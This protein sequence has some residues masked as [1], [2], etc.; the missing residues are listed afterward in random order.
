LGLEVGA[1]VAD[2]STLVTGR[3][4]PKR[5]ALLALLVGLPKRDKL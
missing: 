1:P 2:R 3:D 4:H 5:Y